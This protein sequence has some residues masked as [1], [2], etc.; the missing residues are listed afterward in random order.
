MAADDRQGNPWHV[1]RPVPGQTRSPEGAFFQPMTRVRDG[2]VVR[3]EE[4][5]RVRGQ[6]T[7]YDPERGPANKHS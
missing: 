3:Q 7:V 5:N 4:L 2:E 1:D 6:Q